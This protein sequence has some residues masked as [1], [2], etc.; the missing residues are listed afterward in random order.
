MIKNILP[1]DQQFTPDLGLGSLSGSQQI[2][3]QGN[4][5]WLTYFFLNHLVFLQCSLQFKTLY[6]VWLES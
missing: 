1:T 4:I 5:L 3:E 6:S 2:Q